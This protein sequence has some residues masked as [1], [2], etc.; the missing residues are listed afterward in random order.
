MEFGISFAASFGGISQAR[1]AEELGF[2]FVG[3][4]DSPALEP[5][6]WITVAN[7]VQATRRIQVGP[8]VL[9]PHLRHPMAQASAIAT[10]E[11]L[12]PGRLFVGVGTGFTGRMAMGKRPLT[13]AYVRQFLNQVGALLAGEPVEIDGAVM[14]MLHPPGFGP[15]RP[16]R[17]PFLVAADG[18][19]GIAVARELGGGLIYGGDP[20][21]VPEG[22]ATLQLRASGIILEDDE[23]S[24]SPR[25]LDA[26]R[27]LFALQYHVAYERY[28][29][30]LVPI[31]ALPYGADWLAELERHPRDVRHLVVHDRHTV[32]VNAHDAAFIDR[33][34]DALAAFAA[35]AAV[36]PEQLRRRVD[37]MTKLG[38][39]RITCSPF[40]GTDWASVMRAY[41]K[42][43]GL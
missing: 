15:P 27:I 1:L 3:F 14:Q 5:D 18:P 21:N 16:I 41:A 34:P 2:S 20:A 32:E 29:K 26:A 22:F 36:T 42:A 9:I 12:A 30:A 7:V 13:W 23:S 10:I 4:Y 31:E 40:D 38:A 43:V 8:E 35:Q 11:Q 33:H 24:S 37:T 39:T 19:K 28:P 6:V 17:V 25:V